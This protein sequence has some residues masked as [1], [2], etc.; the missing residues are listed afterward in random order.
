MFAYNFLLAGIPY[1][2][3]VATM[4]AKGLDKDAYISLQFV[5]EDG[6]PW[7]DPVPLIEGKSKKGKTYSKV[8]YLPSEPVQVKISTTNATESWGFWKLWFTFYDE[9]SNECDVVLVEDPSGHRGH[10][11]PTGRKNGDDGWEAYW[12]GQDSSLELVYSIGKSQL[13][14]M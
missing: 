12:L 7:S 1:E 10:A 3:F 11:R 8:V 2:F 4:K 14:G 5:L 9:M 6:G 13:T